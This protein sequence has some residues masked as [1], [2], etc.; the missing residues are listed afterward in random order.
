VAPP[1]FEWLRRQLAGTGTV[2]GGWEAK[3]K[4]PV[5]GGAGFA[6]SVMFVLLWFLA[7]VPLCLWAVG[8]AIGR[9]VLRRPHPPTPSPDCAGE[10][11]P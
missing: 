9:R 3:M 5:V 8:R 2:S 10:G 1:G 11:E 4:H 6:M 7:L